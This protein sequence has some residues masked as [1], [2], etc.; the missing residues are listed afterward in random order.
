MLGKPTYPTFTQ[1]VNALRGFEMREESE[2]H[3]EQPQLDTTI[4]FVVQKSQGRGC[5]NFFR[6][7]GQQRGRGGRPNYQKQFGGG[8]NTGN[9][10]Q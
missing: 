1:F 6:G 3:M 4:A 7:R 9:N 10:Q 2:E 5:G 8:P